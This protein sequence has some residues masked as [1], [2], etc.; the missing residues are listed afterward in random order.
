MES[1]SIKN[2]FIIVMVLFFE[3]FLPIKF[4]LTAWLLRGSI[5]AYQILCGP[6]LPFRCKF[7]PT[8]SQYGL[9]SVQE[10]GTLL[11]TALIVWRILRCNPFTKGNHD[12]VPNFF[13]KNK[14]SK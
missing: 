14:I 5:R 7:N 12:P 6:L 2:L 13:L 9:L 10:Y 1:I 8:C 4:Q 11:G 3:G